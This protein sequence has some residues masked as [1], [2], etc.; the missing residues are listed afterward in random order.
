M[1]IGS[2]TEDFQY[3]DQVE[4][5]TFFVIELFIWIFLSISKMNIFHLTVFHDF[6]VS[7]LM[8]AKLLLQKT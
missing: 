7:L 5:S 1:V 8:H 4:E 2:Q 3:S 6:L